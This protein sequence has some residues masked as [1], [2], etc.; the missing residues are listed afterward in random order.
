LKDDPGYTLCG[1]IV[2]FISFLL[3]GLLP[4]DTKEVFGAVE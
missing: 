2:Y 4:N 1:L 3:P